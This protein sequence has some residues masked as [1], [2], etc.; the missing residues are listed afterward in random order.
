[1]ENV[2]VTT[3]LAQSSAQGKR[4]YK[5]TFKTTKQKRKFTQSL[6]KGLMDLKKLSE[7]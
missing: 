4:N 2:D 7:E 3:H 6:E 5:E 1:M